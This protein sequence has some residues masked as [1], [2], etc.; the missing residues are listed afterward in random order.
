MDSSTVESSLTNAR[1][2]KLFV[3]RWLPRSNPRALLC[4]VHGIGE[5][6]D[7]FAVLAEAFAE[8]SFLVFGQDLVGHGRS[9]GIRVDVDDFHY[10]DQDVLLQINEVRK[11]HPNIPLFL[12]GQSMG[13]AVA[14]VTALN[15][16][17]LFAGVVLIA[18]AILIDPKEA[19]ACRIFVG[20]LL[21]SVAPQFS[22]GVLPPEKLSRN[23][24]EVESYV[25][26]P[27]VWHGGVKA[28]QAMRS[29]AAFREIQSRM[30][31]I[32]FSFI[33]LHGD[34]DQVVLKAGSEMLI[35]KAQSAD[36]TFKTYPDMGH[37]LLHE[38]EDNSKKVLQDIIDW[39]LS[40][41]G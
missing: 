32:K 41:L 40:R 8:K 11:E 29:L 2:E 33:V 36:K 23:K 20:R 30:E 14:L 21:A 35:E 34:G 15:N 19:T 13:G 9:E 22:L 18:P 26:D 4:I 1:G 17:E 27:L 38:L 28:R 25:N 31:E 10:Y 16:P 24:K 37:T 6:V 39:I 5:H 3:K 12:F 7:R